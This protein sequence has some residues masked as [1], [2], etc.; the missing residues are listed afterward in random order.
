M[1]RK[2]W[3]NDYQN[4]QMSWKWDK[5]SS[6]RL[7][8]FRNYKISVPKFWKKKE[9][10]LQFERRVEILKTSV[11]DGTELR[12]SVSEFDFLIISQLTSYIG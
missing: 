9:K 1:W 7:E 8:Y 2:K 6:I 4:Q 3:Q 12:A 10:R 5:T 11:L